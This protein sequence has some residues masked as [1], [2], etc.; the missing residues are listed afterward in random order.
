MAF[1]HPA[2]GFCSALLTC[3]HSCVTQVGTGG[4]LRT[5]VCTDSPNKGSFYAQIQI[6]EGPCDKLSCGE[7]E[8]RCCV[9]KDFVVLPLTR[10]HS[11][12]SVNGAFDYPYDYC[13]G[14]TGT[15]FK[16]KKGQLY[17][18]HISGYKEREGSFSLVTFAANDICYYAIG[19]TLG[20][21]E[22]GSN[23]G[24]T[25]DQAGSCG[26]A[27]SQTSPGVW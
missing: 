25:N 23:D 22:N 5:T 3:L 27:P 26:R 8:T 19:L 9:S 10:L 20:V 7:Y 4:L 2:Q 16:S 13:G 21:P 17:Y 6:L 1:R 11:L 15:T 18:I 24:A 12:H 14:P